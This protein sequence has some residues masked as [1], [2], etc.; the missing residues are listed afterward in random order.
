MTVSK[1]GVA[2]GVALWLCSGAAAEDRPRVRRPL[3]PRPHR[4]LSKRSGPWPHP[5]P[6]RSFGWADQLC[7]RRENVYLLLV[8]PMK[9]GRSGPERHEV[10]RVSADGKKRTKFS[11]LTLPIFAEAAELTIV[12]IALD[13]HG[14]AVHARVGPVGKRP[15]GR[16][17]GQ[18]RRVL[19]P[20][21]AVQIPPDRRLRGDHPQPARGLRLRRVPAAWDPSRDPQRTADDPE[22][23]RPA[24]RR[25]ALGGDV[26]R[27][28]PVVGYAASSGAHGRG[29]ATA[30]STSSRRIPARRASSSTRSRRRAMPS[31]SSSFRPYP[32]PSTSADGMRRGRGSRRA[33][34]KA[35]TGHAGGR[36][37]M[38]RA[39]ASRSLA[40]PCTGPFLGRPSATRPWARR[41]DSPS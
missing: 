8:P 34:T 17:E 25:P 10:L 15:L 11:P 9:N 23:L 1:H 21:W 37:S 24:G 19:R 31:D 16:E 29:A 12:D 3:P 28:R 40:P 41:I 6:R 22:R 18:F 39:Q 4:R 33:I 5:C 36:P 26:L 30:A 32:K 20:G 27:P 38:S 7:D 35:A 14:N 2:L 13:T